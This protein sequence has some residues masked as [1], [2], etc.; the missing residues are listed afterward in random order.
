M[1]HD[2][3]KE[4][5]RAAKL[6]RILRNIM[7]GEDQ[8]PTRPGVVVDDCLDR[9]RIAAAL[10]EKKCP[11]KVQVNSPGVDLLGASATTKKVL[12]HVLFRPRPRDAKGIRQ[13]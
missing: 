6:G 8:P 4:P 7:S 12:L 11:E 1:A 5:R 3:L 13:S 2:I 10:L 9:R